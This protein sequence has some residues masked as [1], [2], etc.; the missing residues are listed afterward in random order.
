L[1]ETFAFGWM[2]G[3]MPCSVISWAVPEIVTVAGAVVGAAL[4]RQE[5][6]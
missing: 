2:L 6:S 1:T 4:F 3:V 5:K